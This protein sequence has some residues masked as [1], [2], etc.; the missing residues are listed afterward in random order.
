VLNHRVDCP[1]YV[2][3]FIADLILEKNGYILLHD[4]W[5]RSTKLLMSFIKT[6][7]I[8]FKQL[9]TGLDNLALYQKCGKDTRDAMFFREF[10]TSESSCPY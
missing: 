7:R 9:S 2:K 8:D 6:N 3:R 5:L 4:A 10:Y 1:K